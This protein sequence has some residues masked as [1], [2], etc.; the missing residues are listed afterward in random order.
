MRLAGE[1]LI[2]FTA[3]CADRGNIH[4]QE[5]MNLFGTDN[6]TDVLSCVNH[7]PIGIFVDVVS[8]IWY[9]ILNEASRRDI[10]WSEVL[11]RALG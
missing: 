6:A 5:L 8:H 4:A 10:R 3:A 11:E 7:A 2:L 1:E 9:A